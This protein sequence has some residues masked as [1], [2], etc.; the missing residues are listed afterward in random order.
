MKRIIAIV[1]AFEMLL[2]ACSSYGKSSA[3]ATADK[4]ESVTKT[5]PVTEEDSIA[6]KEDIVGS[7]ENA[8]G[9]ASD[10]KQLDFDIN[11]LDDEKLLAYVEDS[12]YESLV[13]QLDSAGY[14]V[15]NIEAVYYP[16]EYIEALA[17]NSQSNK[18]FGYT[19]AELE[20]HFQGTRYV[21]ALGDDGQTTVVPM[22]I[23]DDDVYVK[24]MEDVIIG[25]GVVLVCVTVSLVFAPAS[26][27]VSMIFA[28]SATTGTTFALESGTLSFAA[29]AIAKGYETE[30]FDQAI[31]AGVEAGGEGFKWGAITGIVLGGGKEAIALKGATLNG[32]TM[33]EAAKIQKESGFPLELIKQFKSVDEYIVYKNAGLYTKM[34]NGRIALVRDIDPNYIATLEDGTHISNLELMERGK[35]PFDPVSGKRF[36]LH[37]INQDRDGVLAILTKAEHSGNNSIL[38]DAAKEGVHNAVSGDKM[39]ALKKAAFWKALA[40]ELM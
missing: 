5:G 2:T 26:P 39:W 38:H 11:G 14:F 7:E 29:A 31:N 40:A 35:A 4:Q 10:D 17:S 30:S 8:E 1:L 23:L 33:N 20:K 21:F 15:E 32:L 6:N 19:V 34:I 36:D 37:H 16:K 28:A 13:N 3:D 25:S 27:A 9:D 22:E 24:A 12:V 18:Y